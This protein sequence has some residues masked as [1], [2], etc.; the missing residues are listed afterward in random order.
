VGSFG[1]YGDFNFYMFHLEAALCMT[2]IGPL[3]SFTVIKDRGV[4]DIYG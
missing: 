4:H 3:T 1:I 2:I